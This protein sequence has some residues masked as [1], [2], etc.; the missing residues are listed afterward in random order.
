MRVRQQRS[1]EIPRTRITGDTRDFGGEGGIAHKRQ[2]RMLYGLL[3]SARLTTLSGTWNN[4]GV[5]QVAAGI[6]AVFTCVSR[7][8]D[9]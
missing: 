3:G 1:P 7:K 6:P 4:H 8:N 5:F 9:F 2:D